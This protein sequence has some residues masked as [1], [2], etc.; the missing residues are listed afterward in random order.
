MA[1]LRHHTSLP[2][3]RCITV[4]SIPSLFHLVGACVSVRFKYYV[5]RQYGLHVGGKGVPARG[6]ISNN[7]VPAGS[8]MAHMHAQRESG[9]SK[10]YTFYIKQK[11]SFK[12][13]AFVHFHCLIST[14]THEHNSII[15]KLIMPTCFNFI[16][17]YIYIRIKWN[18]IRYVCARSVACAVCMCILSVHRILCRMVY[19]LDEMSEFLM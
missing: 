6:R 1:T 3:E 7:R 2:A 9:F 11:Q 4:W 13:N 17:K 18:G 10:E 15:I 5:I 14:R 12:T 19:T 8:S 16:R